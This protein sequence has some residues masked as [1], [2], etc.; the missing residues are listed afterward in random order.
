VKKPSA[1]APLDS[2][3]VIASKLE[4]MERKIERL[5][6]LYETF[7]SGIERRP[8]NV[9]R[10]ELNRMM[11]ELQQIQIRNAALRFRFQSLMQKWTLLT[12]YWNRTLR[13]IEAGTYRKD[14]AKVSR[15][16]AQKGAPLSEDEAVAL[17]IPAVRARAL[18]ARQGRLY[19]TEEAK[20]SDPAAAAPAAMH[21]PVAA[22]A[23][24]HTPAAPPAVPPP[25]A[26]AAAPPPAGSR[27]PAGPDAILPARA[28]VAAPPAAA[29]ASV[30][31][32]S[33]A[34]V[35]ALHRRYQDAARTIGDGRQ[36]PS[37]EKLKLLL[38]KRVPELLSRHDAASVSFDVNVKDGRVVL[39]ANP[40]K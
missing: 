23:A 9:P 32:M 3:E 13:E 38:A 10:R 20:A 34:D 15:R 30:P 17:G 16:L 33:E 39:R 14:V 8:P 37:L 35:Q 31:G 5:R 36:A 21:T 29:G 19:P 27:A 40:R 28:T 26:A 24:T 4:E 22:P 7:F 1:A 2:P 6:S 12:T 18:V 25:R 11:L